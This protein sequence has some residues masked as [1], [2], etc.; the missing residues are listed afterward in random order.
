MITAAPPVRPAVP[1]AAFLLLGGVLVFFTF[2]R[3]SLPELAWVVFAPF[4]VL[5]HAAGTARRLLAV[6]ATLVLAFLAAVSKMATSEIPWAPW[7][8]DLPPRPG[9]PG[10]VPCGA[11]CSGSGS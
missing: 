3:L 2:M 1:P 7:V 9:H 8:P 6:F 10:C 5:L 4:L 11:T